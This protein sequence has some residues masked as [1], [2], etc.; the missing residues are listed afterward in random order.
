M[1]KLNSAIIALATV[2]AIAAGPV[3]GNA[4]PITQTASTAKPTDSQLNDRIEAKFKA[5]P[6]VKNTT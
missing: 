1:K 3:S 2:S 6:I 4:A 5:D